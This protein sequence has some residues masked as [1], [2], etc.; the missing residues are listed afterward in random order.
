MSRALKD[1]AQGSDQAGVLVGDDQPHPGQP[2]L[3]QRAQE[4]PPKHLVLR[5]AD[6]DA[7][8]LSAAAGGDAGRDHRGHRGDLAAAAD[9]QVG[10]VEEQVRELG[11]V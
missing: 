2:T 4:R 3:L 7:E 8:D 1:A 11:V 5:I 6:I 9:V 10:G